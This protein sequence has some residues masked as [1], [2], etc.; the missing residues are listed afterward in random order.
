MAAAAEAAVA[1][2]TAEAA[3]ASTCVDLES[4]PRLYLLPLLVNGM[5]IASGAAPDR[6][7]HLTAGLLREQV[8]IFLNLGATLRCH[9]SVT[10]FR[11]FL[12]IVSSRERFF[13]PPSY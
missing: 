2:E 11:T 6:S 7:A 13:P 5:E 4:Y 10:P 12:S 1:A 3:A 8:G 9:T